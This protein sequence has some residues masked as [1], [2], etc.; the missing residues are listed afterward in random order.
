MVRVFAFHWCK[1]HH[2]FI[3]NYH[4]FFIT[5]W[6]FRNGF[7]G[8]VSFLWFI[9]RRISLWVLFATSFIS[10]AG[11]WSRIVI[12]L[13]FNQLL[14]ML[15]G[16]YFNHRWLQVYSVLRHGCEY[17]SWLPHYLT[18]ALNRLSG[19]IR[20]YH[21][22]KL[23]YFSARLNIRLSLRRIFF[24]LPYLEIQILNLLLIKPDRLILLRCLLLILLA[25]NF[26]LLHRLHLL[27]SKLVLHTLDLLFL[28]FHPLYYKSFYAI[29][30]LFLFRLIKL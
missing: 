11:H 20:P 29:L 22:L 27:D 6:S 21:F 4:G 3:T 5:L 24:Q 26:M 13:L 7:E 15:S 12:V 14:F 30:E 2:A 16:F 23:G 10:S 17:N 9:L 25:F 19:R 18:L 28:R 1:S 8:F